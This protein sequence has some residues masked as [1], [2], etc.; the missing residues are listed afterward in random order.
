MPEQFLHGIEIVEIDTGERPISTVRSSVIGLIGTAP[1]SQAAVHATLVTGAVV[2]ESGG[3]TTEVNNGITYTS[4]TANKAAN[5]ITVQLKD[6]KANSQTLSVSV[7]GTAITVN[8]ATNSSGVITSTATQV[9]AAITAS[10][11]ASL[12]VTAANYSTS[13]GAGEVLATVKAKTLSGGKDEAFP[14]NT[15]VLIT[16]SRNAADG[17][18]TVGDKDGTLPDALDAIFDQAG[19]M[20]VVVR[21][22]VGTDDA[23]TISNIIGTTATGGVQA[24]LSA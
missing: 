17:L 9:I 2:V 6:P 22:A 21:V 18:D 23:D 14:L 10:S 16:G 3:M 8:L 5:A 13:T 1:N 20:V 24:F 15:P 19:A 7:S 4:V 12:L 11:P